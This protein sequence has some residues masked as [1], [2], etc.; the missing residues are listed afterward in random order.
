M[1]RLNDFFT[2]VQ[3]SVHP[4]NSCCHAFGDGTTPRL[5]FLLSDVLEF[6]RA[7]Y[8]SHTF[9]NRCFCF[10]FDKTQY[11]NFPSPVQRSGT[12]SLRSL[13]SCFCVFAATRL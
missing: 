9:Q 1:A 8:A 2:L 3:F 13:L 12:D 11:V 7:P 10:Y 6:V 4:T 5:S